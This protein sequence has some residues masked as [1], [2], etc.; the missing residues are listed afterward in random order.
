MSS[1]DEAQHAI[2]TLHEHQFGGP[3]ALRLRLVDAGR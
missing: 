1:D 2:E 3:R